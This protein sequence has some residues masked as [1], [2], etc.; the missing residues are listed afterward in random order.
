MNG[1]CVNKKYPEAVQCTDSTCM[2]LPAGKTCA[3]CRHTKHCVAMYGVKA[4]N[5]NCDFFPR[6]YVARAVATEVK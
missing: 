5:T 4:E 2:T 6:R 3:D 1:C